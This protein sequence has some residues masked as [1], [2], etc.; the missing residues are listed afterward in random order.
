[1]KTLLIKS[2]VSLSLILSLYA[3]NIQTVMAHGEKA[4]EPFIR[5][6]TIQ[7]YDV[8]WSKQKFTVNEEISVSGKF[9]VAEDWPVSVPKPDAAFLNIST[10][11]PVLIRTERFLNGKPYVNSVALQPGGDYTFKVVL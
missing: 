8:Q 9:H 4:L 10:P 1:M 6:R 2:V 11:G 5:M 7:W 3:L